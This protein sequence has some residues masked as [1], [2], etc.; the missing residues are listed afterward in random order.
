MDGCSF[1]EG[2]TSTTT[3]STTVTET[4]T[5]FAGD[6][7]GDLNPL[8]RAKHTQVVESKKKKKR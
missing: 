8:T 1:A 2:A 6:G 4:V 3:I 5:N 7:A